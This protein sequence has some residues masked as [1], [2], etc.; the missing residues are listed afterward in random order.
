MQ[1]YDWTEEDTGMETEGTLEGPDCLVF[2]TFRDTAF[3]FA[4]SIF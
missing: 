2:F 3:L 1:N 4:F